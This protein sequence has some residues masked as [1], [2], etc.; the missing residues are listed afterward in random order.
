MVEELEHFKIAAGAYHS[1]M[2]ASDARAES[3]KRDKALMQQIDRLY[4]W[5]LN[6]E[7]HLAD[8]DQT[9]LNFEMLEL[10]CDGREYEPI[11]VASGP[12]FTVA[13][14]RINMEQ[15]EKYL[16]AKARVEGNPRLGAQ[17]IE[18]ICNQNNKKDLNRAKQ[19]TNYEKITE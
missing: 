9:T 12:N 10:K 6:N 13:I 15:E 19:Q 17:T 2:I 18:E 4:V 5:G 14:G 16:R 3:G 8:T 1:V 11:S 7:R